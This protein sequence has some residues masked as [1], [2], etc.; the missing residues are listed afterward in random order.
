MRT[1][2]PGLPEMEREMLDALNRER[3]Q[4]GL[5]AL[6]LDPTVS[7]VARAHAQ[8]MVERDY[9]N[10][11]SPEGTTYRDRLHARELD[12][13]RYGE[14]WYRGQI[15]EDELVERALAWFMDDPPHRDNILHAH[16]EHVGIGIVEGPQGWYTVVLDFVGQ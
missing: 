6:A 8:D 15:P 10:H 4:Y 7:A 11:V 9:W 13:R 3:A 1:P 5:E 2:L 14:N 12:P 16:Y